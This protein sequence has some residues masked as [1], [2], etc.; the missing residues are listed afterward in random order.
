MQHDVARI[1]AEQASQRGL[2]MFLRLAGV[3]SRAGAHPRAPSVSTS[4]SNTSGKQRLTLSAVG[5]QNET[6]I[7]EVST[8]A[9]VAEPRV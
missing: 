8:M 3:A 1:A 7:A 4:G 6:S 5:A 2:T 9:D